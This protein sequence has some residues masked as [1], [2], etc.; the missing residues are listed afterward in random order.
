V[1]GSQPLDRPWAVTLT[2]ALGIG[3][4]AFEPPC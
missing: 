1:T 2:Q 4:N 3:T